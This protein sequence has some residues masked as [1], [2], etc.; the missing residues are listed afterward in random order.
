M[1][2]MLAIKICVAEVEAE[3]W[4]NKLKDSIARGTR[5][6]LEVQ[7]TQKMGKEGNTSNINVKKEITY[8][9]GNT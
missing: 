6:K 9:A 2:C 5:N 3:N 7:T 1:D 8:L 4:L